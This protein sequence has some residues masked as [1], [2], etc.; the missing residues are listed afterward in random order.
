MGC[1]SGAAPARAAPQ[2]AAVRVGSAAGTGTPSAGDRSGNL[3]MAAPVPAAEAA[4][5]SKQS[6]GAKEALTRGP[7]LLLPSQQAI[8]ADESLPSRNSEVAEAAAAAAVAADG[9]SAATAGT[10]SAGDGFG[11][12][13][14]AFPVPAA[15]TAA[16][17]NQSP[18]AKAALSRGP[19]LLLSPQP[20]QEGAA[21]QGR[22]DADEPAA[23]GARLQPSTAAE[24]PAAVEQPRTL[25][26]AVHEGTAASLAG[27][28]PF[29]EEPVQAAHAEEPAEADRATPST[30]AAAEA[31]SAA[32]LD[33]GSPAEGLVASSH[34]AGASDEFDTPGRQTETAQEESAP[35][36]EVEG[37]AQPLK[38]AAA[39]TPEQQARNTSCLQPRMFVQAQFSGHIDR[40]IQS[41][42]LLLCAAFSH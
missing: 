3:D 12:H 34:D 14:A 22:P 42:G 18:G 41:C 39:D 6:P 25:P 29:S 8:A 7:S 20:S 10:P 35:S 21:S 16:G 5:L 1:P 27:Q 26:A 15:E 30:T 13:D 36:V 2:P 40:E 31:G 37:V 23:P 19:S 17:I 24:S 28:A 38:G 33:Q 11:V 4:A 32:L 9:G